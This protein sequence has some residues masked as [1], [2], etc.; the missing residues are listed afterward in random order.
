M[1]PALT[2]DSPQLIAAYM[3]ARQARFECRERT[4]IHVLKD[5]PDCIREMLKSNEP[6]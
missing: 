2:D 1:G 4:Q 5:K 6:H 3:A